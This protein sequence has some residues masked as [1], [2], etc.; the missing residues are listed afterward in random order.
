MGQSMVAPLS[1]DIRTRA[2]SVLEQGATVRAAAKRFGVSVA[3]SVRIG[4]WQHAGLASAPCK[5]GGSR[6]AALSGAATEW[7]RSR[8]CELRDHYNG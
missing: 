5:V 8:I 3:S 2:A 4:Q 6:R 7:K 1:M